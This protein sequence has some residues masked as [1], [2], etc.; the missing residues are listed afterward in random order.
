[1][2][3]MFSKFMKAWGALAYAL[4]GLVGMPTMLYSLL[5]FSGLR[6]AF[7][8]VSATFAC[9]SAWVLLETITAL[10]STKLINTAD[11]NVQLDVDF[12]L[13]WPSIVYVIPAYLDNEAPILSETIMAYSKLKYQGSLQVMI[14][15]N[16]RKDMQAEESAL[17]ARWHERR[18]GC[19]KVRIV[20][21]PGCVSGADRPVMVQF[22]CLY[23]E[24]LQN[25]E[26]LGVYHLWEK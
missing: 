5:P 2:F 13:K 4:I 16:T 11:V 7:M 23:T 20:A 21:N 18:V 24:A 8:F 19:A 12:V 26:Q 6:I 15:Y 9:V 25:I 22:S 3:G 17:K 10:L 14:V 1:M